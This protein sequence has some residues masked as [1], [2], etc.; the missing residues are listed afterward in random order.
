MFLPTYWTHVRAGVG[1]TKGLSDINYSKYQ[2]VSR[3]HVWQ[4][5]QVLVHIECPR[6]V[7]RCLQADAIDYVLKEWGL[8]TILRARL[9][10][11]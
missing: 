9:S 6:H 4:L 5:D 7:Q 10:V 8:R 11:D 2:C 3:Q 1:C